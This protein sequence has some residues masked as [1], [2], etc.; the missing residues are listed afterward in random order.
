[1]LPPQSNVQPPEQRPEELEAPN[2]RLMH[3][4]GQLTNNNFNWPSRDDRGYILS[5][6][7]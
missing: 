2:A 4:H 6:K 3:P 1:M 5:I 7:S